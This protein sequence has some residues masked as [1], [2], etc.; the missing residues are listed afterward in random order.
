MHRPYSWIVA[1]GA[2]L[3]PL[4][5]AGQTASRPPSPAP[6]AEL[7]DVGGR[8]LWVDVEG[9]GDVTVVF[10]AGGGNDSRVWAEIAP[11]VRKAGARTFLYDRAGLGRSERGPTPSSVDDE[12]DGLRSALNTCGVVGPVV[13]VAHSYGGVI[14]LL[15][16]S[17]DRRVAG[18]VLVDAMVPKATPK[19][20]VSAILATYRPQYEEVRTRAPELA[21]TIIPLM[22]A[23]PATVKTLD[24]ARIPTRLPIIDIV[25]EHT[26]T[27]TP[28]SA[29]IW[30]RAHAEFVGHNRFRR[31]V[32]A[33]GSSHKVMV[34]K[35]DLVLDAIREMID[36]VRR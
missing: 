30:R 3:A 6:R 27:V 24:A 34:D 23:Y 16:A 19:S 4:V 12:V 31:A 10:E 32:V 22:E 5:V 26:A 20:E 1:I 29:E 35:P 18:L 2:V 25:A 36:T 14:S 11:R 21:K 28:S 17:K 7:V 33:A 8:R 9:D 15:T 13:L